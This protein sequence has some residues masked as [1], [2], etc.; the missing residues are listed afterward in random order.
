MTVGKEIR[1]KI[2][3]VKSTQK[4]TSAMEMV[5]ASKMRRAQEQ[6]S[7]S[8]PYA[9]RIRVAVS[10]LSKCHSEYTHPFMLA[11][12]QKAIG[13][14]VVSS[15]RGLCG[16]LNANLFRKVVAKIAAATEQGLQVKIASIGR[17]AAGFFG[18]FGGQVIAHVDNYGDKPSLKDVIGPLRV[19][20]EAF[21][22]GEIDAL[23]L[24]SNDFVNTMTQAPTVSE[25]LPL[26]ALEEADN[27]LDYHWDY[28]YEPDARELLDFVLRRY[29]ESQLYQAVV[30]NLACEQA[31]RMVAMKNATENA[32]Q[33]IEE[34]QLIYNKARQAAITKE[35]N[36][37]VAGSEAV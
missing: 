32:G 14:I 17:K 4:I 27:E 22:N 11:R 8:A 6:M 36:E 31:S 19:M 10:H 16:G 7:A 15:D 29:I 23:Y 34:L 28:I 33:L 13:I 21:D 5:A 20:V 35:I 12:P 25:L 30:D 1:T 37:I 3:S 2:G 24:A 18:R 26:A 9:S